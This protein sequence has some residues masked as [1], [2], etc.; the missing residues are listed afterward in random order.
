MN[1]ESQ[2][3]EESAPRSIE[4]GSASDTGLVRKMNEDSLLRLEMVLEEGSETNLLGLFAVADGMGGY[5][6]GEVASR[7]AIKAFTE[8]VLRSLVLPEAQI[9]AVKFKRGWQLP[10][11]GCPNQPRLDLT[12]TAI[13]LSAHHWCGYHMKKLAIL[14]LVD[15]WSQGNVV[16][17]THVHTMPFIDKASCVSSPTGERISGGAELQVVPV[18]NPTRLR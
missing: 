14:G 1:S 5:E 16:S 2:F 8:T 9:T 10:M 3:A 7:L 4:V 18:G 17:G 13:L 6:G 11:Y 15:T 12:I